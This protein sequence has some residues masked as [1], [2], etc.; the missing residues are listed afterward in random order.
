MDPSRSLS[1]VFD[2][3]TDN[4][5]LLN[6]DLYVVSLLLG[7]LRHR[8]FFDCISQRDGLTPASG[9]KHMID[10]WTSGI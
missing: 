7:R 1:V 3:G 4:T 6:D 10:L 8:P 5:D 2:V 9:E